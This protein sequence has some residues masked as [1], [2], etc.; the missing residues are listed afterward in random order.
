MLAGVT[1]TGLGGLA[2]ARG[3]PVAQPCSE[4]LITMSV[5]VYYH[6]AGT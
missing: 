4:E 1:P 2:V 6:L 5:T 3:P